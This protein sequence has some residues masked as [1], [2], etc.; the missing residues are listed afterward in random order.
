MIND[1]VFM[2]HDNKG[3]DAYFSLLEHILEIAS[4]KVYVVINLYP[5][6]KEVKSMVFELNG[7]CACGPGDFIFN[8]SKYIGI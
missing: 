7:K 3:N 8:F 4:N 1:P 2:N 6:F 5:T